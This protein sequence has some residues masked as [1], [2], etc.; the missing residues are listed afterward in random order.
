MLINWQLI[1][2]LKLFSAFLL[3]L[4]ISFDVY[5]LHSIWLHLAMTNSSSNHLSASSSSSAAASE[6][7]TSD[8]L[9]INDILSASVKATCRTLQ[10]LYKMGFIDC[11]AEDNDLPRG[12]KIELPLWMASSLLEMG[13]ISMELPRGYTESYREVLDADATVVNLQKLG[14]NFYQTGRHLC[15]MYPV[16]CKPIA[17]SLVRTFIERVTKIMDYSTSSPSTITPEMSNFLQS[18]DNKER[19]IFELAQ[20]SVQDFRRWENR[21]I[22]RVEAN[23]LIGKLKKRKRVAMELGE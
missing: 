11:A 23:E 17:E 2:L 1:D 12:T 18:L 7:D 8:Y 20:R 10:P 19:E 5:Q 15:K 6:F 4:F 16:D 14:P 13:L 22:E 3:L 9:D 21:S